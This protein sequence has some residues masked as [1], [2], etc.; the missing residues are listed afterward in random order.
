ME[1]V[2][3]TCRMDRADVEFLDQLGEWMERD[4]SYMVKYAVAR[5]KEE[6]EWQIQEVEKARQEVR[7]GKFLTEE[8]FVAEVKS[9]L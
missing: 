7:E 8:Q 6:H 4:R 3:V 5:L 2:N 9:W 1:K